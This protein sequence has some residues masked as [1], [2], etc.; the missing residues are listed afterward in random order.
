VGQ[1]VHRRFI[2]CPW[3]EM[4]MGESSI[5]AKCLVWSEMS[6]GELPMGRNVHKW[7]ETPMGW[8]VC[9]AKSL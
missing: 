8:T 7:G 2:P 1:N 4:S 9:G 6:M 3:G 5:W